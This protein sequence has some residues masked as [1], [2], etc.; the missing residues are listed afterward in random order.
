MRIKSIKATNSYQSIEFKQIFPQDIKEETPT[1]NNVDINVFTPN[2]W[3]P[4][5]GFYKTKPMK[6]VKV[7]CSSGIIECAEDHLIATTFSFEKA[8]SCPI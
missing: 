8:N 6:T 1:P 2:G 5:L 7:Q 4:V 3:Q